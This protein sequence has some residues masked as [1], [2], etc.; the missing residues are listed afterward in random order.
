V[1]GA[2]TARS[3]HRAWIEVD[4]AALR[5]NLA[6]VRQMAGDKQ[7]IAVVK[8][9]AYGHGADILSATLVGEG[10]ERLAV[11]TVGEAQ[12]LRA[13]GIEA[14]ILILWGIGEPEATTR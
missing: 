4:H 3:P 11:A 13:V 1:S 5:H 9:D 7:V 8:A 14:P 2:D 6:A 10:V 12:T